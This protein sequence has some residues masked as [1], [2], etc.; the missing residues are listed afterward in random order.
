ME[1]LRHKHSQKQSGQG[2]LAFLPLLFEFWMIGVDSQAQLLHFLMLS[3]LRNKILV[4]TNL[5]CYYHC[6]IITFL[7]SHI[8]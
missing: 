4:D 5:F 1:G 3:S 2:I 6:Y 7:Q 8:Y